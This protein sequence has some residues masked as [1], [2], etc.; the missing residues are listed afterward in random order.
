MTGSGSW[1]RATDEPNR[2]QTGRDVRTGDNSESMTI[3]IA[4]TVPDPWGSMLQERRAGY[5]DHVAWTIPT[6]ITLLPPTQ[7]PSG[8]AG[9][10][11]Q[12]LS[13]VAAAHRVFDVRLLGTST[14]RPVT[15]TSFVVVDAGWPE[16]EALSDAVRSGPLR[17]RLPFPYH[18]HVTL[19]AELSDEV[20]D[21]AEAELRD[22]SLD[23]TV[24]E[25]ERF[26]LT[27]H[28]VWE[29]VASFT[30]AR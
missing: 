13:D 21:R 26:E 16:C 29:S 24:D 7:V 9:A 14:F 28:G 12:H 18:P 11:D 17:R 10:V 19:A 20:H 3:G 25:L 2:R 1:H 15:Q 5:G 30:L 23:F 22:F 4:L 27:D 8:R 6:H